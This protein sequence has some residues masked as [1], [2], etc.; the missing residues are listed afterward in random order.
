MLAETLTRLARRAADPQYDPRHGL[1]DIS[2]EL[3]NLETQT[4]QIPPQLRSEWKELLQE[5]REVQPAF[6]SR[7]NTSSLFDRAGMGR[8]GYDRAQKIISRLAALANLL[9]RRS[10]AN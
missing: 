2:T 3:Q 10:T 6:P 4:D 1:L 8:I 5:I 9:E 7:R